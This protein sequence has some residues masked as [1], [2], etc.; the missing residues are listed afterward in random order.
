MAVELE[1]FVL[2]Y[3]HSEGHLLD[4]VKFKFEEYRA[5]KN[6]D[7][8]FKEYK[9]ILSNPMVVLSISVKNFLIYKMH[10]ALKN[11]HILDIGSLSEETI[12]DIF[13]QYGMLPKKEDAI[14][15]C[16][17][18]GVETRV[19]V[20]KARRLNWN[21]RCK[22]KRKCSGRVNPLANTIF[23]KI[24]ISFADVFVLMCFF[25]W[26]FPLVRAL[27]IVNSYRARRGLKNMSTETIADYFSYF[28]EVAEIIASHHSNLFGGHGK[29]ILV[30]QTFLTERKVR[31]G[32][33]VNNI[34]P[35]KTLFG[36]FAANKEGLFFS[37]KQKRTEDLWPLIK[38][39]CH[40]ETPIIYSD[41]DKHLLEEDA[42]FNETENGN[43][44]ETSPA[45]LS[46]VKNDM[47][48]LFYRRIRLKRTIPENEHLELFMK[49]IALVF[50]GY[51]K[52]GLSMLSI[53]PPTTE[54]E[55]LCEMFEKQEYNDISFDEKIE[56]FPAIDNILEDQ[57]WGKIIK[58]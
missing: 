9:Q 24:L 11:L 49:D 8:N 26:R 46:N 29:T 16:P 50:P 31:R 57:D 35:K 39:C 52:E 38:N 1:G 10:S 55:N 40:P 7:E 17:K 37:T 12:T 20:D 22:H 56:E 5:M 42:S 13:T 33:R 30:N 58:M 48:L 25:V 19:E 14:P 6:P 4:V 15:L 28:R 45:K 47:A 21:W 36:I 54:S 2:Y 23:E 43:S 34:T 53:E 18:C 41:E 44:E 27:T 3:W 32:S 51:G